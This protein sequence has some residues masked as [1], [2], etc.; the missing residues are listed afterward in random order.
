MSMAPS[1]RIT[2]PGSL[3]LTSYVH[4]TRNAT[5]M[6]CVY[7]FKFPCYERHK[8]DPMR[9]PGVQEQ[10]EVYQKLSKSCRVVLLT[11][12]GLKPFGG[13]P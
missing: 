3:S 10:L 5:D 12:V 11:P 4:A 2:S 7:E 1:S 6:Q 9:S 13:N 8:L